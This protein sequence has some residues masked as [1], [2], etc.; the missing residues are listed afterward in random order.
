MDQGFSL[1]EGDRTRGGGGGVQPSQHLFPPPC[2]PSHRTL[3]SEKILSVVKTGRRGGN[4][5][6]QP[7][8][9]SS[10]L[11]RRRLDLLPTGSRLGPDM[12][13]LSAASQDLPVGEPGRQH[14]VPG[15]VGVL[16]VPR[17][18]RRAAQGPPSTPFA[19]SQQPPSAPTQRFCDAPFS[20]IL[21]GHGKKPPSVW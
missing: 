15:P 18:V 4:T 16:R 19:L 9:A 11:G 1:G 13:L 8:P 5:S 12:D 20:Q 17:A 6:Q 21:D 7:L 14:R 3:F 2:D 10:L